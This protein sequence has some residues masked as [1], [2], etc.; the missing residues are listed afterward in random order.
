MKK[1]YAKTVLI[2][3]L[4]LL[5]CVYHI[6][7]NPASGQE[8]KGN[9]LFAF[10][11]T[12][13]AIL[14]INMDTLDVVERASSNGNSWIT[15]LQISPDGKELF[16]TGGD[17]YDSPML[18]FSTKPLIRNASRRLD[19]GSLNDAK[20]SGS[21]VCNAKL[22]PNGKRIALYCET[23]SNAPFA[24][25]DVTNLEIIGKRR[26]FQSDPSY[27]MVFSEDSKVL[28]ILTT[29]QHEQDKIVYK[30][31]II[32]MDTVT[33]EIEREASLP[34]IQEI[35]CNT[36]I[37]NYLGSNSDIYLTCNYIFNPQL[38]GLL[39]GDA[40]YPF[41][42]SRDSKKIKL[43]QVKSGKKIN[44]ISMPSGEGYVNEI[45][46]T[47]DLNKVLISRGGYRNPGEL[48]IVDVKMNKVIKRIMLDWGASSNVV[49]GYE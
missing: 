7:S 20:F 31:K 49:F 38:R 16:V 30:N 13:N 27:Q 26:G 32:I 10:L 21:F 9:K 48:T 40:I 15:G 18:V 22:S 34:K 5:G 8:H 33:G 45:T 1:N 46:F 37:K 44:E 12:R 3:I 41:V 47:P 25:I 4:C 28:Y 39:N 23:K 36:N 17:F 11:G 2:P 42:P 24:I 35:K 14:K 6:C 19:P 29:I 43:I